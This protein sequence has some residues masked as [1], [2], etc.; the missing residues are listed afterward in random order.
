MGVT[1]NILNS[2]VYRCME[3]LKI[4]RNTSNCQVINM[5]EVRERGFI[6]Q[7]QWFYIPGVVYQNS[8]HLRVS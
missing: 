2:I 5:H 6:S 8:F 4:Y 1:K 7:T 3:L